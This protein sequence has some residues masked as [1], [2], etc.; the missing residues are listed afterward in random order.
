MTTALLYLVSLVMNERKRCVN[1]SHFLIGVCEASGARF[2]FSI[3]QHHI[4][5]STTIGLDYYH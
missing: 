5:S 1:T 2:S 3:V 4:T